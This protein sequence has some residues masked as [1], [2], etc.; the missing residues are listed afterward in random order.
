MNGMLYLDLDGVFADFDRAVAEHCSNPD[1]LED[2]EMWKV[3]STIPR[4]FLRVERMP[5]ANTL[6][7]ALNSY[8]PTFLTAQPQAKRGIIGAAD[9]KR[10]WVEKHYPGTPCIVC[11][12]DEKHNYCQP[13]DVLLDDNMRH[14]RR[15]TMAGGVFILHDPKNVRVSITSVHAAMKRT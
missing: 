8:K 13:G 2:D 9:D 12:G 3:V 11:Y 15:W 6:W 1:E 14:Q 7:N 4:F 5:T 10:A